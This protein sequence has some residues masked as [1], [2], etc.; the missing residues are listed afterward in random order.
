MS[1]DV[2]APRHVTVDDVDGRYHRQTLITWWD[3]DRLRDATVLVVGAG[4]LGNELVKN[5]AL[6]G[7]G[8]VIVVDLDV[9]ENSNLSRCV[10]FRPSDEGRPKAQVVA[11]AARELNPDVRVI[12]L[13]GDVR[14]VVG[15]GVVRD[16]DVVLGGLDNRE[17]RLHVNQ[18]CRKVGTT[19]VDGAI[20]GLQ[21]VARTFSPHDGPCYECTMNQRDHE[22]VAA[23]RSCSLLTRDEMVAGKVPTTATT[24]SLIAALQVQEA[25]KLLH[26]LDGDQVLRG[27][28]FAFNGVTHD[29]YVV[30][31]AEHPECLAHDPYDPARSED[32]SADL[33]FAELLALGRQRLAAEH[34]V[35]ETEHELVDGCRCSACGVERTVRRPLHELRG[36][37]VTCPDCGTE[38]T[39][40]LRHTIEP[41]DELLELRPRDLGVPR[42]DAI[43]VRDGFDRWHLFLDGATPVAIRVGEAEVAA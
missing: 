33:T 41:G 26:G 30:G 36:A 15:L 37:D 22:L 3:Q 7:V 42:A 43:T 35:V 29:S 31:Y 18:A 24:A 20:E 17:A 23:R 11:A 19:W 25:V 16:V 13:V 28:G 9:V 1:D 34:A 12:P 8:T 4:A 21:G 14:S 39:M 27:R 10:F 6:I 38:M 32:V 2:D 40:Q 5:L